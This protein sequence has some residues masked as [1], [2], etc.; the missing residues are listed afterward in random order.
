MRILITGISGFLGTNIS[1]ALAKD[2]RNTIYGIDIKESHFVGLDKPSNIQFH[3][4]SFIEEEAL[5]AFTDIDVVVHLARTIAP[6]LFSNEYKKD[7]SENLLGSIKLF[8]A[9]SK[10]NAKK[11]IF[12]SS[13][14]TVYGTNPLP[15][16]PE[17]SFQNRKHKE[18][19]K[20]FPVGMYGLSMHTIENYLKHLSRASKTK[21]AILRLSNPFGPYQQA[22]RGQGIINVLFENY[23]LGKQSEIWGDGSAVRDYIYVSDVCVAVQKAIRYNGVS[24]LFNIG[25]S[26]G[27]SINEV[28]LSIENSLQDSLKPKRKIDANIAIS[29]NI[30]D[31]SKAFGE[32]SWKAE[33][34]WME[35]LELTKTYYKSLHLAQTQHV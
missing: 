2:N 30:L 34:E 31:T 26:C 19:D 24:N 10:L 35:G 15:H 12:I 25:S 9:A 22:N 7:I 21:L 5:N 23:F 16:K 13:G 33:T 8:E 20:C 29:T 4:G 18:T 14:G 1:L 3:K 6:G 27:R 17:S 11:F 32:L 28:I